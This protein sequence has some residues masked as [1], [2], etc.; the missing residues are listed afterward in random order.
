M[1]A[2]EAY[3][4]PVP[5]QH[6]HEPVHHAGGEAE[7]QHRPGDDEHLRRHARDEALGLSQAKHNNFYIL[8]DYK[9]S[10]Q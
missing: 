9:Q 4:S 10:P 3:S 1:A 5:Q 7:D 8:D 2:S 6:Q